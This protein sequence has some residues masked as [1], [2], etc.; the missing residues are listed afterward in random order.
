MENLREPGWLIDRSQLRALNNVKSHIRM[1]HKAMQAAAIG[2]G[3]NVEVKLALPLMLLQAH[4]R[5]LS[6]FDIASEG[7]RGLYKV[8]ARDAR[9]PQV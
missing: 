7:A 2:A 5:E 6:A 1:R 4:S 9:E 3:K 8:G